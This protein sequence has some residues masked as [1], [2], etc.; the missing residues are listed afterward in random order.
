M[1]CYVRAIPRPTP[2]AGRTMSVKAA[3]NDHCEQVRLHLMMFQR[4]NTSTSERRMWCQCPSLEEVS[5]NS[6]RY[7]VNLDTKY[8]FIIA[9]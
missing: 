8:K 4:K 2:W 5:G 6:D 7:R 3:A 9:L 1:V